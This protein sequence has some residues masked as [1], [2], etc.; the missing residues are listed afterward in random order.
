VRPQA[1]DPATIN[2]VARRAG[3]SK[4]TVS[5]VVRRPDVVSA[6]TRERVEDAIRDLGYRP[7]GVARALRQRATRV[8]G[9]VVPDQR[10]PFFAQLVLG[11]ERHARRAGFGL[12]IANT[13]G[14]PDTEDVQ[15]AALLERRVDA[16]LV[17]GMCAGSRA[18]EEIADRGV[19]VMLA[20]FRAEASARIGRVDVD[21]AAALDALVAHLQELGH[22]RLA[23]AAG[24]LGEAGGERREQ[25]F[26]RAVER[27]GLVAVALDE[28]PTAI[29]AHDDTVAIQQ[30]DRLERSGRRVP[31]DVSVVGFDDIPLA[32]HQRISLTT[33]STDGVALGARTVDLLIAA[34]QTGQ[35]ARARETYPWQ[36]VVRSST[37][38]PPSDAR[39][40]GGDD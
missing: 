16:I 6:A 5:N 33:V 26:L 2:D 14:D 36:L 37:A 8:I 17:G 28:E 19:P 25:A 3:V 9:A 21:E 31:D 35:L 7:N 32:S 30:I 27:R 38:R 39:A 13:G 29:V 12:L 4:S 34:T 40:A 1:T 20:G 24:S 18:A 15:V 22:T 10:N 11:A 23:F